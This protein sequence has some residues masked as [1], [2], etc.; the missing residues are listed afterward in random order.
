M[1]RDLQNDIVGAK[2]LQVG[3]SV[4][5]MNDE[6]FILEVPVIKHG[7]PKIYRSWRWS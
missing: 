7:K 5:F 4:Y 3:K 6:I 1:R 2:N